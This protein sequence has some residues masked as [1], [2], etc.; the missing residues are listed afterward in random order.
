MKFNI[1]IDNYN[2][3]YGID[4]YSNEHKRVVEVINKINQKYINEIND[5]NVH[6]ENKQRF[7]SQWIHS[8]KTPISV[9]DLIIQ[10]SKN[11]DRENSSSLEEIEKEN[12][13]LLNQLEQT[14]NLF[15]L[16]EFSKDYIPKTL[17]LLSTIKDIVNEKKR[18][19]IYN[20]IFPKIHC[21]YDNVMIISDEKWNKFMLGQV[22]SNAIKYSDRGK[23]VFFKIE[24]EDDII[25][26]IIEDEGVGIPSHDIGRIFQP[27]FTGENGRYHKNS[28]GIGLYIVG[29]IAR[30]LGHDLS[31]ESKV[32]IGT[33]FKIKY[34][35][36]S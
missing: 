27:F 18:E 21:S 2:D 28:S 3:S 33:K 6:R 14:L 26:L 7:I 8:M 15:R 30:K 32:G 10:E 17:D 35:S 31:L 5:L 23:N 34:L 29:E 24:K 22:I 4:T 25:T 9:I 12:K 19:F 11:K 36:K 13:R 1:D 16:E 20:E